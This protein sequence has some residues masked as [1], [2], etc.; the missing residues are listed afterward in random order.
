MER[1][2]N[3]ASWVRI[4]TTGANA[5]SYANTGLTAN[6]TYYYRVQAFNTAGASAYS[7]TASTK[8]RR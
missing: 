1:S 8:T 6:T 5:T 4:A 7:N 2:P 3:G